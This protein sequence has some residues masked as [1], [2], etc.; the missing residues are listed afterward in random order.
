MLFGSVYG[1]CSLTGK[2]TGE[3][4][5]GCTQHCGTNHYKM[6]GQLTILEKK[7]YK[8]WANKM[9][10]IAKASYDPSDAGAQWGWVWK[11]AGPQDDGISVKSPKSAALES[12][13]LGP[14]AAQKEA[15]N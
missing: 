14:K 15:K 9:S 4:D 12:E 7:D 2:E 5:I 1:V 8:M 13:K 3:F 11:K 10:R 6:K